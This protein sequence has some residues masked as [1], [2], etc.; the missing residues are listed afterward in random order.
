VRD[1]KDELE[2]LPVIE[3]DESEEITIA[4]KADDLR[5]ADVNEAIAAA[6]RLQ[7]GIDDARVSKR[8]VLVR[9]GNQW[10]RLRRAETGVLVRQRL[11]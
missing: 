8:E 5:K 9:R 3:T 11:L 10:F 1:A 4:I 7:R 6:L 2:G